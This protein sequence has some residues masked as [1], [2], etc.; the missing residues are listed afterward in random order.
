MKKIATKPAT[1]KKVVRKKPTRKKVQR[2]FS[3]IKVCLWLFLLVILGIS[4]IATFF[5][6]FFSVPTVQAGEKPRISIIIDDMGYDKRSGL[7]LINL[8]HDLSFSF[9]PFT[10]NS[11]FLQKEARTN[12]RDVLLHLALEPQSKDVSLEPTTLKL[13]YSPER[14]LQLLEENL[15]GVPEAIGVNN[16]MGSLFTEN[17][18][19]MGNV[20]TTVKERGLFFVDSYTSRKSVAHSTAQSLAMPA[21]RRDIFLDN[22]RTEDA[23]CGQLEKLVLVAQK[24]GSSIGIGHPHNATL[25]ALR[26]CLPTLSLKVDIVP[27]S[28]LFVTGNQRIAQVVN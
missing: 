17:G 10:P 4:I 6:V 15:H 27:V 28:S 19:A 14:Q 22:V 20:L 12:G 18:G 25:D 5:M 24:K 3:P 7:G 21:M 13:H 9:L 1:K 23:I 2:R 26:K 16:H 8:P 11:E